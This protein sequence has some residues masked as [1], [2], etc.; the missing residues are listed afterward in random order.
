[1]N[2]SDTRERLLDAAQHLF[3]KR[4]I[5]GTSLRSITAHAGTNLASVNYHFGSKDG[6]IHAVFARYL[7]PTNQ[8]RLQMLNDAEEGAA[9]NPL[10]VEIILG[11]F[12]APP[13]RLFH[14]D[15]KSRE[16]PLLIS[17][18]H[19]EPE[20]LQQTIFSQFDEVKSRFIAAFSR[21]LPHIPHEELLW[22]LLFVVGAMAHT[23]CAPQLM[24]NIGTGNRS[25][26]R[27]MPSA[28]A[29]KHNPSDPYDKAL[30][31]LI[32]FTAAGL[33]TDVPP[34]IGEKI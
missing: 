31:R 21:A 4:G 2:T 10:A 23:F 27:K 19:A 8:E 25:D 6:L 34:S 18:L 7:G 32:A 12:F 30:N 33:R 11:A 1:M 29:F 17:R 20:D 15:A 16:F 26:D 28:G 22:R 5:G 13:F 24:K 9:P 14:A 3:V